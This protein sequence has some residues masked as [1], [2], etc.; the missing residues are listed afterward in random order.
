MVVV[1]V[2]LVV[3]KVVTGGSN[4]KSG[5]PATTA[6]STVVAQVTAVPASV[7][8]T[9]GIG[10]VTTAPKAIS[11]SALTQDGKP[12][13]LYVGAEYCPY[14]A[15]ERWGVAVALARFGTFAHLGQTASSP[16]DVYPSTATLTFHGAT[17]A[18]SDIV[19]TAK[20]IQSNQVKNGAYT[21][22][23]TLTAAETALAKKYGNGIP[24]I[25]IGGKY[26]I[27]GASFNP[28]VLHGKTHAQIARRAVRPHLG[29]RPG[30]RR[31]GR[32][33]CGRDLPEHRPEGR[34][35]SASRR[36]Y[37]KRRRS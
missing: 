23:D 3:V 16:S 7:L 28:Q 30:C 6:A 5:T 12:L 37:R 18:S 2:A 27:N 15:T 36:A 35:R 34:S 9:V 21:T 29:H 25:D 8:N 33:G 26:V 19:F 1:I 4:R 11:G 10:S 31:D 14:C 32:P 22:L 24:F 20:E 13:V 17:F